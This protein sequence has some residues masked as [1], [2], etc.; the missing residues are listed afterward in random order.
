[1]TTPWRYLGS[2]AGKVTPIVQRNRRSLLIGFPENLHSR[3]QV[4]ILYEERAV[5]GIIK[6]MTHVQ[7]QTL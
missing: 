3:L 1:M 5:L 7:K 4:S 2:S 6:N